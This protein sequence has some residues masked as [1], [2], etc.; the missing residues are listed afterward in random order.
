MV[1]HI[2]FCFKNDIQMER[3]FVCPAD[4]GILHSNVINHAIMFIIFY[5]QSFIICVTEQQYVSIFCTRVWSVHKPLVFDILKESS[6]LKSW[7]FRISTAHAYKYK[8]K[9]QA[10]TNYFIILHVAKK[11]ATT[12][13]FINTIIS[14]GRI[15]YLR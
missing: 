9:L 1:K 12:I 11:H 14:F 13:K 2:L 4:T 6:Q 5:F 10:Q 8:T 7:K 3:Y 15:F